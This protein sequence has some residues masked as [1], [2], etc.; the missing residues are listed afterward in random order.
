MLFRSGRA[1]AA[2]LLTPHAGELARL[3]G[4][5]HDEIEAN[6]LES[7]R[8]A[9]AELG[10]TILL[11]GSTTVVATPDRDEPAFVNP[12]GTPWLATGGSG[13]VLTGLAGALLA[14]GIHPA[15]TAAAL[16]AFLH[17]LA[18]RLAARGAP[19]GAGDVLAAIPEAIRM[20]S[21]A[22]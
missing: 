10:V 17:G 13:D 12:T 16:A 4:A 15:S 8:R 20:V 14:Q 1:G 3:T 6:R 19:V 2:T 18:G 9:A 5:G 22:G 11:K 21:G 7:A